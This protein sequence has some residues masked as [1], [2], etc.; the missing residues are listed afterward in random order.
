MKRPTM[1]ALFKGKKTKP[2]LSADSTNAKQP[3]NRTF[4]PLSISQRLVLTLNGF[5][6]MGEGT[7]LEGNSA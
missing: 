4:Y 5:V 2:K 1:R 6:F 7:G 3:S